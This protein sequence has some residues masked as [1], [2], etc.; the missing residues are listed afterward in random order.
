[1]ILQPDKLTVVLAGSFNPAILTPQ[2]ISRHGLQEPVGQNFVVEMAT[3]FGP[4]GGIQR[5][6]FGGISYSPNFNNITFFVGAADAVGRQRTCSA[7]AR[8][9]ETLPHTPIQGVGFNFVFLIAEPSQE[10]LQLLRANETLAAALTDGAEVVARGW[11]NVLRWREAVVTYQ[12][13]I[14]AQQQAMVEVNFHYGVTTAAAAA[15]VLGDL[16]AYETHFAAAVAGATA[17]S[18]QPLE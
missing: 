4:I 9:L 1:V 14:D 13:Q 7:A 18:G 16:T 10:L 15:A 5:F 2:W 3:Q 17:L 12:T 6:T 11:S 8:M